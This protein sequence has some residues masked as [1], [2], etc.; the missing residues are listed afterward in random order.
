MSQNDVLEALKALLV[1]FITLLVVFTGTLLVLSTHVEM[2]DL[3]PE[4]Q[5]T[6]QAL[7]V[8]V[9]LESLSYFDSVTRPPERRA[10]RNHSS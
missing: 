4:A 2:S 5:N 7:A 10:E 1:L 9:S 6:E 8:H 3:S